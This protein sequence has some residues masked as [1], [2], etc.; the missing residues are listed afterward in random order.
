[1]VFINHLHTIYYDL[2]ILSSSFFFFL[3]ITFIIN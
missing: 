1:M 3:Y 2:V